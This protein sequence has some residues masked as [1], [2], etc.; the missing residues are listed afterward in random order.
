MPDTEL[1]KIILQWQEWLI[2]VRNYSLHTAQSYLN[3]LNIFLKYFSKENINLS[4]LEELNIRDFRNFFSS[5][6]QKK[7]SKT[8]IAREESAIKNFYKWLNNNKIINNTII[9]QISSP[10]LPKTLPKAVDV[11]ILFDIIDE[12]SKKCTDPWIGSRDKAIFALLY[13]CGLRISEALSLNV[14]DITGNDL[15]KIRGKGNKERYVPI[16]PLVIDLI[17]DYKQM[18]PYNLQLKD[19]LFLGAR[20]ERLSPRI[21]QRKLQQIRLKLNLPDDITPHSLRH[22]FATHLLAQGTDLR[23][24]Q[25]LLGH[26]SLSS[27]ERYTEVNLNK[28]KEEYKKAFSD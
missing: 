24:I 13:G 1:K 4:V 25:E 14:E 28:I 5:R 18:C 9:F 3:D 23:S 6:A 17:N 8:S 16:L 19:P 11:N 2:S 21:I 27:T 10:K 12:A 15:I 20:G 26:S 7:I 22:S